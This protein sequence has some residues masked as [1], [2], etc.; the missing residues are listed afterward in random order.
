MDLIAGV[1]NFDEN[2]FALIK[3][4]LERDVV[5]RLRELCLTEFSRAGVNTITDALIKLPEIRSILDVASL[6]TALKTILGPKFT[7]LPPSSID[8]NRFGLFHTD[9]SSA[10]IAGYTAHK[11]PEFRVI[12]LGVYLQD[13]NQYGGG[14]RVVPGSHLKPDIYVK[15]LSRKMQI[16]KEVDKSPFRLLLKRLSKGRWFGW[17]VKEFEDVPGQIDVHS[18]SGDVLMW[19]MRLFHRASPATVLGEGVKGGKI[20]IFFVLGRDNHI[21]RSWFKYCKESG[22][23]SKSWEEGV[24]RVSCPPDYELISH[25]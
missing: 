1:D 14:L 23:V 22:L 6:R 13:N 2:G 15:A 9:T 8:R 7:V 12:V 16:R 10:E 5:S 21:S 11:Y 18:R 19:D 24:G 3:G 17:H 4:A 25:A 20:A